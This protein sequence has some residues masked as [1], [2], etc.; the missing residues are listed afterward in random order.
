MTDNSIKNISYAIYVQSDGLTT[1]YPKN[2]LLFVQETQS[3]RDENIIYYTNKDNNVS[4]SKCHIEDNQYENI[5]KF[6]PLSKKQIKSYGRI[7]Y[8]LHQIP[9]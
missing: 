7:M 3:V 2:T 5:F 8:S 4:F 6:I 9:K 1:L